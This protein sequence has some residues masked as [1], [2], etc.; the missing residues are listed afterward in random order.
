MRGDTIPPRLS[1]LLLVLYTTGTFGFLM[2][3]CFLW[4]VQQNPRW[5]AG[6]A[7]AVGLVFVAIPVAINMALVCKQTWADPRNLFAATMLWWKG[8]GVRGS[9]RESLSNVRDLM[10]V[11]AQVSTSPRTADA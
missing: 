1:A 7:F 4:E 5:E 10:L 2:N 3:A 6:L 11:A 8:P 9:L